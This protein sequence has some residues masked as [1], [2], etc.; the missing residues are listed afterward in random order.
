MDSELK[1]LEETLAELKPQQMSQ[2]MLTRLDLTMS[3]WHKAV[4]V[5]EKLVVFPN[6]QDES[7]HRSEEVQERKKGRAVMWRS[8]AAVAIM[9]AA[10]ALFMTQPQ[11]DSKAMAFQQVSTPAATNTVNVVAAE[12]HSAFIDQFSPVS[13]NRQLLTAADDGV[14]INGQNQAHRCIRLE[15]QDR[16]AY[17]NLRGQQVEIERPSVDYYIV[18]IATD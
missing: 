17:E 13:M 9:G 1:K 8:A 11:E 16:H 5:E 18:P 12:T 7:P 2:E 15:Y 6:A 4:P 3:N 14:V 10:T